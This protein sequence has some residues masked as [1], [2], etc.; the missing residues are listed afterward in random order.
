[1]TSLATLAP[2]TTVPARQ[3]PAKARLAL[4]VPASEREYLDGGWWP[5]SSDLS[6]ELPKLLRELWV[7]RPNLTRV[8]YNMVFWAAAPRRMPIDGRQIRLGGFT[9]SDAQP[10]TSI[11]SRQLLRLTDPWQKERLDL[12]VIPTDT[13]PAV[14]HRALTIAGHAGDRRR[15]DEVLAAAAIETDHAYGRGCVD[16]L[17]DARWDTDSGS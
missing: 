8:A 5:P 1:M 3:P 12:L 4:R 15:P 17:A 9:Y 7:T 16:P 13:A 14:A 2:P 11:D 10:P 6:V